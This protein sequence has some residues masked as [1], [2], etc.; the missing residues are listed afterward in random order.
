VPCA[1]A[2]PVKVEVEPTQADNVPLIVG[3]AFTVNVAVFVHP[4]V[5]I[6]VMVVVPA[7]TPVTTPAVLIVAIPVLDDA[8]GVVPCA[9]AEPVKVEVDPIQA[10]KVPLIVGKA[11]TV[12]VAVFVQPSVFI[13]VI[14]VVPAATPVTTPAV[15]IVAIPVLEDAHGVVP[16]AVADPVKVEVNP[17]QAD[18]VPLIVGKAFTVNVAVFVQPFVF[19]YVMVVVPAATPVT[20]PAVLIVAIPVLEDAHGVVPCAVADPVKVEVDP[21]QADKVPLIVG[22]AFTVNV[23]VFVQPSVFIY[24]MVVVPAATPVTTPAVLI[25][26]IPVLE[27]AHGVV[28]CAVA[29]PVKVEVNPIQADKV[30]LIVGKAFTVNVAVFV[31]PFVFIYVIVVVPAAT[32]VTTPAVLIVAIPVLEEA[33]GVVPCA[34]AEPV[35]VDV[36]PIQQFKVPL[37]VGKALTVKVEV[38]VQPFVFI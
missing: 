20:T 12:N 33:H 36:E 37:I 8:H 5:F 14:V 19:I 2:E 21:I 25:V 22:K 26:A 17:T 16:C 38:V 7:A 6:Y 13:Y 9:V 1:V 35:K 3:K 34:V 30:P 4:F 28:P 23:A 24:V 11:F 18:K 29:D 32:P 31:Q 10:D 27:D 15:L